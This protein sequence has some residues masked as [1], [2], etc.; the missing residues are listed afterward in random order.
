MS[1]RVIG[2]FLGA[3]MF[4]YLHLYYMDLYLCLENMQLHP[5]LHS[6]R[7][8]SWISSDCTSTCV[9]HT[10]LCKGGLEHPLDLAVDC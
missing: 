3:G 8:Y 4:Q 5:Y 1:N 9:L 7:A 10:Y 6:T 2:I